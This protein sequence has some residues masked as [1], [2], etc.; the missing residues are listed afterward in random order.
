MEHPLIGDLNNLT[1]DELSTKVSDLNS[2][3][4]MAMRTGNGHLC[5]QIR[6]A[7]ESY[8][9][10]YQEKLQESY[11]KSDVDFGDKIKIQ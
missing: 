10:K 4:S 2:K 7:I 5:N 8:Q 1:L 11:K 9:T 3:L 6:M